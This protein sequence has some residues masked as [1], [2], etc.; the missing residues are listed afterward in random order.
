MIRRNKCVTNI[1]VDTDP[2]PS[3]LEPDSVT[4]NVNTDLIHHHCHHLIIIITPS[5]P[6]LKGYI[7]LW[8]LAS[9][10][11]LFH[12][13]RP[14]AILCQFLIPIIFKSSSTSLVHLFCGLCLFLVPS[15]LTNT[16]CFGILSL[17]ILSLHPYNLN[18]SNFINFTVS[19][20]CNIYIS[21]VSSFV[22]LSS[23]LMGQ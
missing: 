23:S 10:T 17:F 21:P 19:A 8:T 5:P 12:S 2:P 20:P 4:R 7:L 9:E 13:S 18:L 22:Q 16:I 15:S 6:L 1:G 3:H 11:V 14:L